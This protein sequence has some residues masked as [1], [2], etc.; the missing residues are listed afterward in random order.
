[1]TLLTV[2]ELVPTPCAIDQ[3][4]LSTFPILRCLTH[5]WQQEPCQD[6]TVSDLQSI[7]LDEFLIH[8]ISEEGGGRE[9]PTI[10][11]VCLM[12]DDLDQ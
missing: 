2:P 9:N 11:K 7:Q 3:R 10:A 5:S 6:S 1:M 4:A 8:T 12:T